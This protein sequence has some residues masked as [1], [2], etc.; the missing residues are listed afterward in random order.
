MKYTYIQQ[1]CIAFQF[2]MRSSLLKILIRIFLC[3]VDSISSDGSV[4]VMPTSIALFRSLCDF[5]LFYSFI[6]L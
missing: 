3:P 6:Y 5:F 4:I 2:F 1:K